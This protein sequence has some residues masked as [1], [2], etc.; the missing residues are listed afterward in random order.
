MQITV[1]HL[2]MTY[3][4][5]KQALRDVSLQLETPNL[6]GLLGPNGAGKSTLMKLL[7]AGLLP[8]EGSIRIDGKPLS[9]C[10]KTLKSK[11][12]YLPQTFGL[13]D[14][15]TVWQ[16]LDYMAA[17][18]GIPDSKGAINRAIAD[19]G[20]EDKRKARIRTLSG[21]QRQRV[22]IAQAMLGEPE[23]LIFDEPTVGLDPEERIRFRNFFSRMAQNK[24]VLLS[25]HIIEDVQSVC[26]LLIVINDGKVL[27]TGRPEELIRLA[28]GHVGVFM[29]DEA[30]DDGLTILITSR[31]NTARG[32]SCRGVADRLPGY[33]QPVEPTLEDAYLFLVEQGG[34]LQ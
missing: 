24:I 34:A 29:E 22:G 28:Q 31:V 9:A 10:E 30:N 15:L 23:F 14:E 26:N 8:T 21:G 6:I 32:V 18:K 1:D 20:L 19:T 5:G 25:T 16:F 2:S 13:F 4:A 17:L 12:G 3:P 27:F 11:L 7:V 33:A